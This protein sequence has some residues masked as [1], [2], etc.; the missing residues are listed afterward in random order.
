LKIEGS[1]YYWTLGIVY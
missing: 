1:T